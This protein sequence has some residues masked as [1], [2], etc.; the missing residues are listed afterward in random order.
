EQRVPFQVTF[1]DASTD[2][3]VMAMFVLP[4]ESVAIAARDTTVSVPQAPARFALAAARGAATPSGDGRWS[5]T[6]PKRAGLYPV[7]VAS[8]RGD[9]L[10][11]NVFVMVPYS[12]MRKGRING[13]RVGA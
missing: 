4:G 6:A 11:L 10:T 5:W 3:R 8:D 7:R 9:T 12:A 13:Y 2:Y 1:G